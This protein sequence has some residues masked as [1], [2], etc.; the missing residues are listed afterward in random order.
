M[1]REDVAYRLA[2]YALKHA[3]GKSPERLVPVMRLPGRSFN[4][5]Q[6]LQKNPGLPHDRQVKNVRQADF[7]VVNAG[8]QLVGGPKGF[9][10]K[11]GQ[12]PLG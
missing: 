2:I 4:P 1:L 8:F 7:R 5:V 12:E 3:D 9:P 6:H 10:E 11:F